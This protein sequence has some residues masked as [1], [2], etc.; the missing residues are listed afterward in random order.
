MGRRPRRRAWIPGFRWVSPTARAPYPEAEVYPPPPAAP[1]G[2]RGVPLRCG[3]RHR[4]VEAA[5]SCAE[6]W[7]ED[8]A[9]WERSRPGPPDS[10]PGADTPE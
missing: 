4:D 6:R 2:I 7:A 10:P 5:L 8:L 9:A 1:Q 3:H